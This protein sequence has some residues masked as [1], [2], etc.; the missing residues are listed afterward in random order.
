MIHEGIAVGAIPPLVLRARSCSNDVSEPGVL[1]ERRAEKNPLNPIR[2]IP[3]WEG[4]RQRPFS[5]AQG[6]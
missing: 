6:A 5:W 2:V 1:Y 4:F 3:A